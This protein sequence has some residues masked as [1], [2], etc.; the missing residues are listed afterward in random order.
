MYS[1][2]CV[3]VHKELQR[4]LHGGFPLQYQ[5]Y[6]DTWARGIHVRP[7]AR[8]GKARPPSAIGAEHREIVSQNY[9]AGE[10][11]ASQQAPD[12]TRRDYRTFT[13]RST[14]DQFFVRIRMK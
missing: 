7:Y 8:R 3:Q 4:A 1:Q 9:L 13:T 12:V 14:A 11:S 10:I 2:Q 5:V 6:L